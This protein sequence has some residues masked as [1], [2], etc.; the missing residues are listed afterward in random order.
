MVNDV[1]V[2]DPCGLMLLIQLASIDARPFFG[3]SFGELSYVEAMVWL[4]RGEW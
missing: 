2:D 3:K 4:L 1:V